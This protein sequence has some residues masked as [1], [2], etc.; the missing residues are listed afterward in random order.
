MKCFSLITECFL[1]DTH[2]IPILSLLRRMSNLE[3]LNLYMTIRNRTTYIDGTYIHNEI[4]VHK[5]RLHI[6]NFCFYTESRIKRLSEYDIQ[7][8]LSNIKNRQTTCIV[9]YQSNMGICHV[10]S[11]PYKFEEI[12]GLGSRFPNIIFN[13]VT[14]LWLEDNIPFEHEFFHRIAWS[15]PLLERLD[16]SNIEPQS[17]MF[18]EENSSVVKY[19]RLISL[20]LVNVCIDYLDQFLNET[21]AYLPR[22]TELETNYDD[23]KL[24]TEYFTRDATR[25][26][27]VKIKE[28]NLGHAKIEYSKNFSVY[29]PL[30]G[31]SSI[32]T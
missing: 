1:S 13:H 12:A 8:T 14:R 11:L 32:S 5:P 19:P 2:D 31:P 16:V 20:R 9:N 3:E 25:V 15:F 7:K 21:K 23:L 24:V 10:F 17:S 26:H 6:F 27:C 18:N 29:F 28:L 30:I 4:L 22:L